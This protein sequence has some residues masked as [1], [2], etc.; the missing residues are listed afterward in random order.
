MEKIVQCVVCNH[1][2]FR[3]YTEAKD[4]YSNESFTVQQCNACGFVFTNPRPEEAAIGKYYNMPDYMSHTSH[5]RG[6]VQSVYR[7]ARNY[8]KKRKLKLIQNLIQ[9]ENQFD[10]LDYGCGTGDFLSFMKQNKIN[11]IG[12]EP[13][14]MARKVANEVNQI[15]VYAL[16]EFKKIEENKFD[17]ITLWHVL[18]HIYP[19]HEQLD[20]FKLW[21]RNKGKLIIAVP[22]IEC[23]D[24]AH[25]GKY[26][27]ALDVPRHIYHFSPSTVQKLVEQHGFALTQMTPLPLD[28]YYVSM[29]SEWHKGTPKWLSFPKAIIRGF[30]SNR[31]AKKDG[32][33]SSLIYVFEKLQG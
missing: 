18:E 17:V 25:Y 33:Y 5:S 14:E 26:W 9:K 1:T 4:N 10:L 22:N 2:D 30:L 32:N 31:S 13:D 28:A 15:Q 16:D 12:I 29:R 23:Y 24:S 20:F 7:Y 11:T 3:T 21:L 27:D 6:M 19:V 8:M